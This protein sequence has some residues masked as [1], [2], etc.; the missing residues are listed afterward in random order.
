MLV[1]TSALDTMPFPI[2]HSLVSWGI[3]ASQKS[4]ILAIWSRRRCLKTGEFVLAFVARV[5]VLTP[6]NP[7]HMGFVPRF[8]VH[9]ELWPVQ[10]AKITILKENYH[11]W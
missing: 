2:P 8:A 9:W 6:A 11:F 1:G 4:S 3:D 10:N 7:K 5:G